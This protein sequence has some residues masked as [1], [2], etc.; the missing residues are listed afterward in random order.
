MTHDM[1]RAVPNH[2]GSL[3]AAFLKC[4]SA[5]PHRIAIEYGDAQVSYAELAGRAEKLARQLH[6]N[7]VHPGQIVGLYVDRSPDAIAAILGILAV[8]AAYL[9]FDPAYPSALLARIYEESA[10][11]LMLVDDSAKRYQGRPFWRRALSIDALLR[12]KNIDEDNV[13]FPTA[14]P[15]D[16]VYVMYTSGST[17]QP[18]GVMVPGRA[19]LRLV[20]DDVFAKL[21]GETFLQLAPLSFDASTFEIW[22]ALLNGGCL[23]ILPGIHPSLDEIAAAIARHGVTTLWLTAG[24]FHLMVEQRLDGLAPLRQLLAG[25]DVLSPP[26]VAKALRGLPHCRLINGYGPTEN[27]TFTCCYRIQPDDGEL[28]SIPIGRPI[29]GT[30][31]HV[32]DENRRPVPEGSEGELYIGGQGLALGY[33]RQPDA[34]AERF[35]AH[36]FSAVPGARLYRSGDR[37]RIRSDGNLEF[38]GRTDRQVKINGKRVELDA[39][40]ACIRRSP[41][42]ADAVAVCEDAPNGQ[43]RIAVYVKPVRQNE[44]TVRCLKMFLSGELP[45]YMQPASIT[46]L[47]E[48]P[49]T[50]G[51][52]LD[53]P[54]LQ[55]LA[56]DPDRSS[57]L[58]AEPVDDVEAALLQI[59]REVLGVEVV[60]LDRN[61]FDIGGTS[62]Q[63]LDVHVRIQALPGGDLTMTDMFRYCRI[64]TLAA[65]IRRQQP[66]EPV[67]LT[68]GDRAR[69][70]QAV[71]GRARREHARGS[72]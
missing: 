45:A 56:V 21:A 38:L 57:S 1:L 26:I 70:Q 28:P 43:R 25:G 6:A 48:L 19:I 24:L 40:E 3:Y 72:Q 18:K 54:R 69:R 20:E 37:V 11:A 10:P 33:L 71:L 61:F 49:L 4:A 68:V 53:R 17:G 39:I 63:L 5:H 15:D 58:K 13:P 14:G 64:K 23:A 36:P 44:S 22:A 16:L 34:T 29:A 42:A 7:G 65:R 46:L 8:G 41:L 27:T 62:L 31:I 66:V 2:H 67:G 60:D 32:L 51:G 52:K 12:A 9:P 50:P 47:D 35:I 55:A 59:W 30:E